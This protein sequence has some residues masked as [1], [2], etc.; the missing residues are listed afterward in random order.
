MS[1]ERDTMFGYERVTAATKTERVRA[2]FDS[3]ADR[4]DVMNDLM[5][6]GLHRIWKRLAVE[7]LDLRPQQ[8]ILDL[9]CGTGDLATLIARR[10]NAG[11]TVLGGDMNAAMLRRGR[12]RMLDRGLVN[13]VRFT[14]L[15]AEQLPFADRSIDRIIIGFGLRNVTHKTLALEEMHRV[16]AP[17]G[18]AVILEFSTVKSP[19]LANLYEQYSFKMLPRIGSMVTGDADSYRYLAESIR[20][21]PDQDALKLMMAR[22]GFEPVRYFNLLA[23][24][25]AVHVGYR[26]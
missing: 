21:H 6:G 15:N 26:P 13:E 12:D 20:V 16:L 14:Q 2:V 4:Y 10:G 3:V 19:L 5:S 8:K 7:V 9:A 24:V 22:A 11:I 1:E 18:R 17:G 25:V 23:G